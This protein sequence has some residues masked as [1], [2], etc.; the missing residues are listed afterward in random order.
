M[1][2]GVHQVAICA[3]D[4]QKALVFYRDLLGMTQLPRSDLGAGYWLDAGRRRRGGSF[5]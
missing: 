3:A 1:P 4:A 5:D 2:A